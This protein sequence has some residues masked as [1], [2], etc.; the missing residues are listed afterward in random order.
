MQGTKAKSPKSHQLNLPEEVAVPEV[1][2]EG[3][4]Y[5]VAEKPVV[6]D[7]DPDSG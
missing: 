3:T 2:S 7:S 4:G 1:V 5:A 6:T